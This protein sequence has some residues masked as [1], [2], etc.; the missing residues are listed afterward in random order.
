MRAGD[1]ERRKLKNASEGDWGYVT[2]EFIWKAPEPGYDSPFERGEWSTEDLV[3]IPVT[4]PM[5]LFGE[6]ALGGDYKPD[7]AMQAV[8]R[9]GVLW[10]LPVNDS[11]IEL[12]GGP[13]LK[14]NDALRPE[15]SKDQGAMLWEVKAKTPPLLGPLG[16]ECLAQ[17]QPAITPEDRSQVLSD[18]A[19]FLP[20]S[21]GK[22]KLG[23]KHRWEPGQQPDP[24]NP[25]GLMQVYLGLEIGR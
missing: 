9:T 1:R 23:A 11:A 6:V 24:R 10:R 22:L 14:Y 15:K 2:S 4:G 13:T 25:N 17:A 3:A 21:G 20:V 7:Q 18:L 16:V 5:Y 19:L 12:R 8:W